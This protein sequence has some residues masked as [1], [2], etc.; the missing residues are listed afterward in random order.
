MKRISPFREVHG[1]KY[2]EEGRP[3]HAFGSL[4]Y[5]RQLTVPKHTFPRQ[6]GLFLGNVPY[7][8]REY[9]VSV[10]IKDRGGWGVIKAG[11]ETTFSDLLSVISGP[12]AVLRALQTS[13]MNEDSPV[14]HSMGVGDTGS[15][16]PLPPIT[17][18]D[19]VPEE[20]DDER[21]P[22]SVAFVDEGADDGDQVRELPWRI[23]PNS[24]RQ[25]Q[26]YRQSLLRI[27][28]AIR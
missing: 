25:T 19:G 17:I 21:A 14:E 11:A 6:R 22:D 16:P 3:L 20:I 27:M 2:P 15:V 12:K 23:P 9:F 24:I 13:S 26:G 8:D 18:S 4:A 7:P 5:P 28:R 10:Y 1:F